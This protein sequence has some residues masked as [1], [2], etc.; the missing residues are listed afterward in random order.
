MQVVLRTFRSETCLEASSEAWAAV[1]ASEGADL[2]VH[3]EAAGR[4]R[5][6]STHSSELACFLSTST[7][8]VILLVPSV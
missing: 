4:G 2:V 5:R 8:R 3:D 7:A 6:P 1:A